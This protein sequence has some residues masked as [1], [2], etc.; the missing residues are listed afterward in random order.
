MKNDK[1]LNFR[2]I[3]K[4]KQLKQDSDSGIQMYTDDE[5]EVAQRAVTIGEVLSIGDTAFMLERFGKKC[6]IKVGDTVRYKK[7][8]AQWERDTDEYGRAQGEW[9]GVIND[10]DILT[11]VEEAK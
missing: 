4:P 3:I 9:Y 7:Y 6:P 11:I 8:A 5:W 1:A 10:D 2:I